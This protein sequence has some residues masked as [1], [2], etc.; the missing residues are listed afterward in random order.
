MENNPHISDYLLLLPSGPDKVHRLTLNYS[1]YKNHN[2]L[3][4][5]YYILILFD[6][7]VIFYFFAFLTINPSVISK[8]DVPFSSIL[9]QGNSSFTVVT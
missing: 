4:L 7:Q 1:P 5:L 6:Y 9:S 2:F 3:Y 8:L